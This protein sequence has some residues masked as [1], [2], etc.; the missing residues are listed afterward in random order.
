MPRQNLLTQSNTFT[1]AVWLKQGALSITPNATLAPDGTSTASKMIEDATTNVHTITQTLTT[2]NRDGTFSVW[3]KAAERSIAYLRNFGRTPT[4]VNI[5]SIIYIDLVT[6]AVTSGNVNTNFK[7]TNVGNG[8]WRVSCNIGGVASAVGSIQRQLIIGATTT[9]NIQSYPGDGIS[10]IY[11]WGAQYVQAN[12]SGEYVATTTTAIGVNT[13]PRNIVYSN[14]NLILQSETFDSITWTKNNCTISPNLI[15]SPIGTLTADA[16]IASSTSSVQHDLTQTEPVLGLGSNATYSVYVHAGA[17]SWCALGMDSTF[18][19]IFFNLSG[20]GS[21]GTN[22]FGFGTGQIQALGNG[23]YRCS[24]IDV[25]AHITANTIRIYSASADTLNTY[26]A[27]D[28]TTPQIYVW[29]AQYVQANWPGD[30][31]GTTTAA[32]V[33]NSPPR[34]IIAPTNLV[35]WSE[36]L[37]NTAWLKGA[38]CT[39]TANTTD[40]LDP[41]G[42][43]A[44]SKLVYDGSST[45]GGIRLQQLTLETVPLGTFQC[46]GFWARVATGTRTILFLFF[47]G[48]NTVT[49]TLTTSWKFI[50]LVNDPVSLSVSP[51]RF[52]T[53]DSGTDN[54]ACT[55]YFAF[56]Q[57]N[58]GRFLS[59]Y[60]KTQAAQLNTAGSRGIIP[61]AQNLLAESETFT[62]VSFWSPSNVTVSANAIIAPN[63]TLTG[64]ALI[65]ANTSTNLHRVIQLEPAV[66][67]KAPTTLSCYVHA[68]A[69]SWC[70]LD[71][72][73]QGCFA[74]FNLTG[75]GAV[76][77]LG[78]T[79]TSAYIENIGDG[80][81]RCAATAP[82]ALS[83]STLYILATNADNTISYAATDTTS[84]LIYVWGAQY[85]Q[86]NWAGT[87]TPTTL[88]ASGIGMPP[89]NKVFPVLQNLIPQSDAID[90]AP[91]SVTNCTVSPDQLINPLTGLKTMDILSDTNDGATPQIHTL[92]QTLPSSLL[93]NKVY[94]FSFV[95]KSA[96]G[97]W[98]STIPYGG[99]QLY[100]DV[101]NGVIGSA[102]GT[103]G[104]INYDIRSLSNGF[105]LCRVIFTT[106]LTAQITRIRTASAD[107]TQSYIGT[108]SNKYYIGAIQLVQ[109][110]CNSDYV[111]TTTVPIGVNFPPRNLV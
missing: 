17:V 83:G 68:G 9:V 35:L 47:N 82:R 62:N 92:Q 11:I 29:G 52:F 42:G 14:Q 70:L 53:E 15:L 8:W 86:A 3:I 38:G 80:W 69:V 106:I 56:P 41:F 90:T 61:T 107:N 51:A 34:N 50:S 98:L 109:S 13:P 59:T 74:Y 19:Q 21:V 108:G 77:T 89:R 12:W 32:V 105:F 99:P 66:T 37:T 48:T 57:F 7:A 20:A 63:G 46:G 96:G 87:Y 102:N 97:Q 43:N 84:P 100:F 94:T 25:R 36:D 110:N 72:N 111:S 24:I 93:S 2:G 91:W 5:D 39:A 23:W 103:T 31:V 58:R 88:T 49:T 79:G 101:Q 18:A 28:T 10:G 27:T 22:T 75:N 64:S 16:L 54:S 76:G 44:A 95:A 55:F 4:D 73:A 81:Y 1:D 6:G 104:L 26:A 65:S 71:F 78:G 60:G 30:Y 85:V 40:V 67:F 33:V 45:I